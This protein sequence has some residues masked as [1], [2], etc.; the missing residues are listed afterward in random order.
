MSQLSLS[1]QKWHQNEAEMEAAILH[2]WR[3]DIVQ[4]LVGSGA[5]KEMWN[6]MDNS[7]NRIPY[8]IFHH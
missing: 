7:Y 4:T 6:H 5:F 1:E 3:E 2:W 8:V